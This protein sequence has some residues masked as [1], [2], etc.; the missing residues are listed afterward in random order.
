M[1]AL[2]TASVIF[3]ARA[4]ASAARSCQCSGSLWIRG[5]RASPKMAPAMT[6]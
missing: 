2:P 1:A 6:A 3:A 4:R 5:S